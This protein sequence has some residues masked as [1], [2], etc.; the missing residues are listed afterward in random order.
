[1]ERIERE[2]RAEQIRLEQEAARAEHEKRLE[3]E[4]L[5]REK[6][7]EEMRLEQ[8]RLAAER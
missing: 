3:L 1:M 7:V 4:R 2:K 6:R 8:E 5:E